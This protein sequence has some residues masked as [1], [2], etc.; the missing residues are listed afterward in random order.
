MIATAF[1][2]NPEVHKLYRTDW[3]EEPQ[4]VI[5]NETDTVTKAALREND[6]IVIGDIGSV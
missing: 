2:L 4:A 1:N 3:K 6:L 5:S